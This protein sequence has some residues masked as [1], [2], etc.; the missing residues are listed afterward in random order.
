MKGKV[1]IVPNPESGMFLTEEDLE[2]IQTL[3]SV[4]VEL[5]SI[6]RALNLDEERFM[7]EY[8]TP[9]SLVREAV[10]KALAKM[11][12]DEKIE[13]SERVRS[14]NDKPALAMAR[15]EA[16][17]A[18]WQR[19]KDKLLFDRKIMD[20]RELR[21][22][23]EEGKDG[24]I[25][26]HLRKYYEILDFIRSLH[27][28]FN[29]RSYIIS[30]VRTKWPDITY[31]GARKLFYDSLNFFNADVNVSRSVWANVYA[32]QLDTISNLAFERGELDIAGRYKLEAAKLRGVGK[33]ESTEIPAELLDRKPVLYTL[34]FKDLGL[35]PADRRELARMIDN[36]EILPEE[37]DRL[38]MEAQVIPLDINE[39]MTRESER[40][41]KEKGG[42]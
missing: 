4:N 7:A 37:K 16:T 28:S 41:T 26:E 39:F 27:T 20:L 9:G 17:Q 40:S 14:G 33:E 29:S 30:M 18:R 22:A 15:K 21:Q 10:D 24:T 2:K 19:Y 35:P 23:V 6:A 1:K 11:E 36:L 5:P 31:S 13:L 42:D 34:N 8:Q 25:P 32:D 38:K 3:T 12:I